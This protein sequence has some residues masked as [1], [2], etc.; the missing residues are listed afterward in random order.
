MFV[1]LNITEDLNIWYPSTKANCL[2][3]LLVAYSTKATNKV[4]YLK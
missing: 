1:G 4:S 2:P 3:Y